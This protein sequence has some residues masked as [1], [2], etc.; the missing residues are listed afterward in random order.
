MN[1]LLDFA[2]ANEAFFFLCLQQICH[3]KSCDPHLEFITQYINQAILLK[4]KRF[5]VRANNVF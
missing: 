2:F 4:N 3:H 5:M 1:A